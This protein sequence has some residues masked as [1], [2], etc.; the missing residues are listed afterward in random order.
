MQGD[1]SSSSW[2]L[3]G[4]SYGF[5]NGHPTMLWLL[6]PYVWRSPGPTSRHG[7]HHF[8][9][10]LGLSCPSAYNT[11]RRDDGASATTSPTRGAHHK[12][13]CIYGFLIKK[14]EKWNPKYTGKFWQLR[15]WDHK[16][17]KGNVSLKTHALYAMHYNGLPKNTGV[18]AQT[19]NLT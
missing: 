10:L 16:V 3:Q 18:L 8:L 14:G 6:A 9:L 1:S 5:C 15:L 4:F 17:C 13:A 19:V 2:G 12:R 11:G 7:D